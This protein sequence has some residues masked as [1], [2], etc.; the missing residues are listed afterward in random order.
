MAAGWREREPR[1]RRGAGGARCAARRSGVGCVPCERPVLSVGAQRREAA[2]GDLNLRQC[3]AA[4][5]VRQSRLPDGTRGWSLAG[6]GCPGLG[7]LVP[8]MG[9]GVTEMREPPVCAAGVSATINEV[10]ILH[11]EPY[12]PPRAASP[13][14]GLP[15]ARSGQRL[16]EAAVAAAAWLT[17]FVRCQCGSRQG[18][19]WEADGRRE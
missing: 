1:V 17:V 9:C 13:A 4:A 7:C 2:H 12:T 18:S 16:P 10:Q 19:S 6:R 14:W 5:P 3:E 15:M 8:V 11:E